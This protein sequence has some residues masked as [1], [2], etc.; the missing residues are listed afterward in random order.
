AADRT[1]ACERCGA[2]FLVNAR[3]CPWC[4]APRGAMRTV[5]IHRWQPGRGIVEAMGDLE[6]LPL[7]NGALTLTR[8]HTQG[9]SGVRARAVEVTLE[10]EEA[11]V[12]VRAHG[13]PIGVTRP[14]SMD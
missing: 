7:A 4:S 11:G 14:G 12:R 2:T 9:E 1:V 6:K 13:K 8:R 3:E 5:R 10:R